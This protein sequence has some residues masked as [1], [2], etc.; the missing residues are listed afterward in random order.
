MDESYGFNRLVLIADDDP[1][2]RRQV[3]HSL[4]RSGIHVDE[5]ES[6]EEAYGRVKELHPAVV[7]MDVNMPGAGGIDAANWIGS[8]S[9]ETK[10]VVM[11][12]Q[13]EDIINANRHAST[14]FAVIQKPI[15]LKILLRFVS[16]A[17]ASA[18]V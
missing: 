11:S 5:A 1:G 6:G 9:P 16:S 14:A 4:K 7:L 18:G 17:L 2:Q 13:T 12:G 15:P 8:F 10:V 3:A